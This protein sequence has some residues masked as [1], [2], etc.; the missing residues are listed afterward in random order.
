L[1]VLIAAATFA[2]ILAIVLGTYWVLIVRVENLASVRLRNQIEGR[3]K[4]KK[5]GVDG[6][7]RQAERMSAVRGLDWLLVRS[8]RLLGPVQGAITQSGLQVTV[9]TI[10][11]TSGCL[12]G[13]AFLVLDR[14][15]RVPLIGVA[16]GAV[17]MTIPYYCLSQ[18][19]ARRARKLEEQ[20]P[21][22]IDLLS[23]ALRAG[24]ALTTGLA[25]VADEVPDPMGSEFRLLRDQ[26]TFGLPVPDA[27][28][29][30]A[31]RVPVFDARFF[32][33]AVLTQRDA[34][35]NLSELL[36]NLSAIIRDRFRIRRQVRVVSAH[37]RITGWVLAGLTPAL[38]I[39]FLYLMPENY[40]RFY[41]DPLGR[42]MI[43]I[44]VLLQL[45]GIAMI[46]KIV[47]IEY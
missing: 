27:L 30:F 33:T 44:A 20:F 29:N 8:N 13:I 34:G 12:A 3:T 1:I 23:R 22:A 40:A 11:L 47:D 16:A 6:L 35:G 28:R 25:M 9:G 4:T 45:V 31:L 41:R 39:V 24:H 36:D 7:L 18:V 32:V 37:G 15:T 43:A 19:R 17:A 14:I 2:L 5:A 38:V 42:R 26:Q 46:R 10:V 21:E